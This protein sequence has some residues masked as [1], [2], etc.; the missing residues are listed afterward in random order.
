MVQIYTFCTEKQ[1]YQTHFVPNS[2]EG[3]NIFGFLGERS[4]PKVEDTTH[5]L[6]AR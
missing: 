5:T 3:D 2:D 6:P 4:V 1:L